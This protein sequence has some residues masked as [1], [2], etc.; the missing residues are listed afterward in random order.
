MG[1]RVKLLNLSASR[2]TLKVRV[3]SWSERVELARYQVRLSPLKEGP[4]ALL[5]SFHVCGNSIWI[6]GP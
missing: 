6:V 3:S 4:T 1:R 5:M 2:A